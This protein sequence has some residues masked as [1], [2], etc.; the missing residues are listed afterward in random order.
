M[1]GVYD[2]E[3]Y[4]AMRAG[5][6]VLACIVVLLMIL[7]FSGDT[8]AAETKTESENAMRMTG[9]SGTINVISGNGRKAKV[10]S[11]M[12]ILNG[13]T[14]ATASKS[15]AYISLDGSKLVK[16]DALTKA[17]FRKSNSRHE[18][19]LDAGNLFFNV[20]S[21]LADNE[22]FYIRT[23]NMTM[24][25]KGTC[26][27]VEV[28]DSRHTRVCL[29][30]G[31]LHCKLTSLK[32]GESKT[33]V[34]LA[35]QAA[36]FYLNGKT[37]NDCKIVTEDITTD[38]IRGFALEELYK[39]KSLAA[40]V[41][42][43]SGLD[44]RSL[45]EATVKDRLRKDQNLAGTSTKKAKDSSKKSMQ[46]DFLEDHEEGKIVYTTEG[47]VSI[48]PENISYEQIQ[49]CKNNTES[50]AGNTGYNQNTGSGSDNSHG[51]GNGRKPKDISG[52]MKGYGSDKW[53]LI[54]PSP[55]AKTVI[56]NYFDDL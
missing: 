6:R 18:V 15:Y 17:E 7:S 52:K 25:I 12:R 21:A 31:S 40:K 47:V 29:L 3:I 34:M 10:T 45:T 11:M 43:Q 49:E 14:V 4:K 53:E 2:Y 36:D 38:A 46:M 16:L 50:P 23:S 41:Y 56:N 48:I 20:K 26:A 8:V 30:E 44:F 54:I 42:Q 37:E 27:Q 32:S 39:D 28:V 1:R 35:G 55:N 5:R 13:S 51:N 24:A 33:V 22:T 19:L 9:G